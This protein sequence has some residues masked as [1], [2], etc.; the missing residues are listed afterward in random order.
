M[1]S[2]MITTALDAVEAATSLERDG[3]QNASIMDVCAHTLTSSRRMVDLPGGAAK[4]S[5]S[6]MEP[7]MARLTA[8]NIQSPSGMMSKGFGLFFDSCLLPNSLL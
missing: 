2:Y 8:K 4:V 5:I 3:L 1:Q 7:L 6:T